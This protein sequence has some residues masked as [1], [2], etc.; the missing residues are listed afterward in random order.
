MEEVS[1]EAREVRYHCLSCG[2]R[3]YCT[4]RPVELPEKEQAELFRHGWVKGHAI[5]FSKWFKDV[6]IREDTRRS[7]H[8]KE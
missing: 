3:V 5:G 7:Y 2:E 1:E 6:L 8:K 4:R